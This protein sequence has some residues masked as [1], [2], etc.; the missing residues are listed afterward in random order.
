MF[1][2]RRTLVERRTFVE[3]WNVVERSDA[4]SCGSMPHAYLRTPLQVCDEPARVGR[5]RRRYA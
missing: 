1:V 4:H 5:S 2:K 3:R